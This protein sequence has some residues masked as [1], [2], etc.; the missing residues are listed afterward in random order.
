MPRRV[1]IILPAV[2]VFLSFKA[3]KLRLVVLVCQCDRG[4]Q[5]RAS[6][7]EEGVISTCGLVAMTSAQH[8]EGRP[9]DPGQ[10]YDAVIGGSSASRAFCRSEQ[11]KSL[12]IQLPK[13]ARKFQNP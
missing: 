8:A 11:K 10:V 13:M 6:I 7:L 9:F 4:M 2:V 3:S 5:R 1:L 12:L